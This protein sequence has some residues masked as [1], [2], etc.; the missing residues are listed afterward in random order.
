M[1]EGKMSDEE[2]RLDLDALRKR[3]ERGLREN[4][5]DLGFSTEDTGEWI[6]MPAKTSAPREVR[7][8]SRDVL[9]LLEQLAAADEAAREYEEQAYRLQAQVVALE[10]ERAKF[11]EDAKHTAQVV[12]EAAD[13]AID[14]WQAR[15]EAAERERDAYLAR[16]DEVVVEKQRQEVRAIE[17]ERERD[18][19]RMRLGEIPDPSGAQW[20]TVS[21]DEWNALLVRSSRLEEALRYY[22]RE[23]GHPVSGEIGWDSGEV[24]R[25]A[26]SAEEAE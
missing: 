4:V 14:A 3:A 12:G 17:A 2:G 22:A 19:A 11:H 10:R 9:A 8:L 21:A 20:P 25:A 15:A 7:E 1:T 6:P 26:L 13:G 16:V 5:I 18:E 23:E 24:A